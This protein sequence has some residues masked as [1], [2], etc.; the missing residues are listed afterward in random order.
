MA[1][2]FIS[3]IF[4]YHGLPKLIISNRYPRMTMERTLQKLVF[5]VSLVTLKMGGQS[6][7]TNL[8][9]IDLLR[10]YVTKVDQQDQFERHLLMV[11]YACP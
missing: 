4:K 1:I 3:Q 6:E 7:I 2:L 10:A 8:T 11:E 9:I 5:K